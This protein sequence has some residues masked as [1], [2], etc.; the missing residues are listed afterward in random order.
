VDAAAAA[1]AAA[2]AV[3]RTA[4]EEVFILICLLNVRESYGG[5]GKSAA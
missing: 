5:Y 1:E 4:T 3:E 2:R